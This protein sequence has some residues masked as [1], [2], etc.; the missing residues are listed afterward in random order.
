MPI[1]SKW[2]IC[3]PQEF[4][5]ITRRSGRNTI[6]IAL[7]IALVSWLLDSAFEAF[8]FHENTF[9]NELISPGHRE[10]WMRLIIM[11]GATLF[12]YFYLTLRQTGQQLHLFFTIAEN[13]ADAVILTTLDGRIVY[14]NK[15]VSQKLGYSREE[16]IKLSLKDL[17]PDLLDS[18]MK[19]NIEAIRQKKTVRGERVH[20]TKSGQLIPIEFIGSYLKVGGREYALSVIRDISE[21]RLFEK[22]LERS[23]RNLTEAQRIA[24]LGS[25]VMNLKTGVV[26]FSDEIYRLYGMKVEETVLTA[27]KSLDLIH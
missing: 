20:R 15:T 13:A 1:A 12:T 16:L 19:E 27:E 25:Y 18:E 7:G 5:Q 14:A 23:Q 17:D 11:I 22:E 21:R 26:E 8:A 9:V 10:L 3:R 6:L 24:H 2:D 4:G